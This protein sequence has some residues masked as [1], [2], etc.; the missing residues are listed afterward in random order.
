MMLMKSDLS[1]L[2]CGRITA[3]G[4]QLREELF[5]GAFLSLHM[6]E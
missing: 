5:T 3:A 2:L 6:S 1:T 4:L